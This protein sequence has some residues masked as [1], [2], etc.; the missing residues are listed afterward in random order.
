MVYY[1]FFLSVMA[2]GLIFWGNT[3]HSMCIFKLQKRAVKIMVGAGNRDSCRKIFTLL[4]ILPL[5]S[6]Y[7]YSLVKFV[8]NNMDSVT[9]NTDKYTTVS[10]NSLYLYFPL[11]NLRIFQKGSQY[12]GIKVYNNLPDNIN[13]CLVTKINLR[14]RFRNFFIYIH[15]I[16]RKNFLNIRIIN[17]VNGIQ[18][19]IDNYVNIIDKIVILI[20]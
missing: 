15:F 9:T 19:D 13:S 1:A 11:T 12:F 5:P 4:K 3:N 8:V 10:R 16:V 20:Y 17:P 18:L 2:Y 6:R 14:R 7:L